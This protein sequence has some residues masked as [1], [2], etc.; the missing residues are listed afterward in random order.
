MPKKAEV[1]AKDEV[2]EPESKK[3]RK[4][5]DETQIKES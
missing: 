4:S 2:Q 1:I 5:E 3:L